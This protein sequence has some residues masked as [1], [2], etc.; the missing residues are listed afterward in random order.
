MASKT[1]D[2]PQDYTSVDVELTEEHMEGLRHGSGSTFEFVDEDAVLAVHVDRADKELDKDW[3][4]S[5]ADVTNEQLISRREW[6]SVAGIGL[7]VVGVIQVAQPVVD[8]FPTFTGGL[9]AVLGGIH[10]VDQ[11]TTGGESDGE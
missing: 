8:V 6:N 7:V 4:L 2:T 3:L 5:Q 9:L 10:A 1:T 11:V